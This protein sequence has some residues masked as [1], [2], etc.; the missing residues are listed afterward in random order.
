M[1]NAHLAR[2]LTLLGLLSAVC[3]LIGADSSP[4]PTDLDARRQRVARLDG[5]EQQELLRKFERFSTL[6]AEEQQRL[7][8]LE[9]AISREPRADELQHVLKRYH[10]WL[11][12]LSSS[13]RAQLADLSAKDRVKMIERIK[14]DQ[15]HAQVERT[16][17]ADDNR[18]SG[19][20]SMT[21][22]P[23]IA[24]SWSPASR[25]SIANG[26]TRQRLSRATNA[27]LSGFRLAP[28]RAHLEPEAGRHRAA[29]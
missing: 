8:A 11:K 9:A 7:R 6:P 15:R 19:P 21:S 3:L 10:E 25:P 13:Q 5:D 12:T 24:R 16:L 28:R 26:S 29:E 18:E 22:W 1:A 4:M 23:A 14:R 27:D 20:G 2:P 17:S